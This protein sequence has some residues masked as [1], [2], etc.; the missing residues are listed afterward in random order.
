M[1][2]RDSEEGFA[3]F[4]AR[5]KAALTAEL[6]FAHLIAMARTT[7]EDEESDIVDTSDL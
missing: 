2:I 7:F 3:D 4:L 5:E 6:D 1:C